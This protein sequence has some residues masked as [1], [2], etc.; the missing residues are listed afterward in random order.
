[1]SVADIMI[2]TRLKWLRDGDFDGVPATIV[3]S[4][5]NLVT[6]YDSVIGEPKIAAFIAKHAN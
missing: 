3:D 2:T 6:L 1:M 4:Y 5:P